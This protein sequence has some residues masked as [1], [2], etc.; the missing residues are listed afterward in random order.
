MIPL[1]EW[2]PDL[3]AYN[4]PGATVATNV[5]PTTRGYR[6]VPGLVSYTAGLDDDARGACV[7]RDENADV[8]HYAGDAS[9]L[10]ILGPSATTWTDASQ[11]GGY[12]GQTT[13]Y[14]EFVRFNGQVLA[15]NFQDPIQTDVIGAGTF[16]DLSADAPKA[17][18]IAVV[19]D[20][21]VCGNT[22]DVDGHLPNRVRWC[23]IGDETAWTVSSTTQA[24]YQNLQGNGGWI[25]KICGGEYGVIIQERAVWRMTYVGSPV[26]FQFDETLPGVGTPAP[27]SV[28]QYGNSI[29]MLAQDG[30]YAITNGL[31]IQ[32]LGHDKVDKYFWENVNASYLDKVIGAV[33]Y[34][35][36]LVYWAY[37]DS[38]SDGIPNKILV[39][40]IPSGK[41]SLLDVGSNWIYSAATPGVSLDALDAYSES[42]DALPYSLD[43]AVWKKGKQ[44]VCLFNN[45]DE[46]S[47]FSGPNL[48]AT[49]DTMEAEVIPG[50][51]AFVSS[52]RPIVDGCCVSVAMGTRDRQA[53]A[54]TW[55]TAVEVDD[56][57]ECPQRSDARYHRARISIDAA[58]DWTEA[59]GL[60]I[61]LARPSGRR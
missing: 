1:G 47:F 11:V 56:I 36:K 13:D 41:W 7:V 42:L 39:Y 35:N 8:Y 5:V 4:N 16:A 43:S 52:V 48:A 26:I 9:K 27:N 38:T 2:L 45:S 33:D 25:Q 12:T 10:Y 32:P 23:G 29:F 50:Q 53:D 54:V 51:R 57:G 46:L 37:P 34:L 15:T 58:I 49:V 40:M 6:P 28:V 55:A 20:F 14:W 60:D 44:R 30:F 19:K 21:V 18:H 17:Y 31:S 61:T 3:S 59:L 22:N 24:D